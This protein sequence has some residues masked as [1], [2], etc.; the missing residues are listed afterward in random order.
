MIRLLTADL[1][2]GGS[3]GLS[4][5]LV[6]LL[7]VR[8]AAVFLFRLSQFVGAKVSMLGFIVKQ[9]NHILTG[10]DLAWQARIGAGLCLYHPTGVVIGP[11]V[12]I[13][14]RCRIQQ[15]VT[16]GGMGGPDGNLPAAE[17]PRLGNDVSIGTGACI[18]GPVHVGSGVTVG[19]NAVVVRDV[20][21]HETVVGV[22]AR[23][24]R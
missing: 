23:P 11:G 7:T 1:E 14:E 24:V 15:G 5:S 6:K 2:V 8:G 20:A 19:A 9:V 21:D 13:G 16:L 22:P 10:A 12:S 4:K 17:S 18:L 3:R